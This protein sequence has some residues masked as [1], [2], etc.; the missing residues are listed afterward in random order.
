[1]SKS[2]AQGTR[3]EW[4]LRQVFALTLRTFPHMI[5]RLAEEGIY[6]RGDL[7]FRV[8]EQEVIIEARDRETMQV[9]TATQKAKRK[10]GSAWTIVVWKRKL[11]KPGHQVR[12]QVGVP[13]AI[14]PLTDLSDMLQRLNDL[15]KI[16]AQGKEQL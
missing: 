4:E 6:D 13:V 15:E 14:M 9:H 8:G 2:K 11:K 5:V 3:W 10:A 7:A 16:V 1:M 12:T